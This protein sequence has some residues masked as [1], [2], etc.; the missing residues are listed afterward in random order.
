[1]VTVDITGFAANHPA[2]VLPDAPVQAMGIDLGT[3]NSVL[4]MARWSPENPGTV[5]VDTVEVKQPV[6]SGLRTHALFPSVVAEAGGKRWVG[7]GA[8]DVVV[9]AVKDGLRES[10]HYFQETRNAMGTG[11]CWPHWQPLFPIRP[12]T[13]GS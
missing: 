10:R 13:T 5:E 3:T 2:T 8:R 9:S 6:P 11:R 12:G 7:S 4:A 1:M